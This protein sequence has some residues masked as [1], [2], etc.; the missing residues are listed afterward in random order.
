[1]SRET[2]IGKPKKPISSLSRKITLELYRQD[3]KSGKKEGES[4][5]SNLQ[6]ER[7]TKMLDIK[8]S[9]K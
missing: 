8:N 2:R 4:E 9:E 1:V 3:Q 7:Y 5:V 6:K